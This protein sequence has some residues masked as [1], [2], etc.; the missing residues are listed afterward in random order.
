MNSTHMNDI[1]R[2]VSDFAFCYH[3]ELKLLEKRK[4]YIDAVLK[5]GPD[6]RLH[7]RRIGGRTVFSYI[8][9]KSS[10]N[11]REIYIK[12][13]DPLLPKL[14]IKYC[15]E[16][17]A[18]ELRSQIEILK[19]TPKYYDPDAIE[20]ILISLEMKFG[21]LMP[22]GFRSN[23]SRVKKWESE[24]YPRREHFDSKVREYKTNK[25][26]LVCSKLEVLAADMLYSLNI[27]YHYEERIMLADGRYKYPDFTMMNPYTRKLYYL[28]ICGKMSDTN[29]VEDLLDKILGY[30][31]TG[32]IQGDNLLLV[33]ESEKNTFDPDNLRKMLAATVLK[34]RA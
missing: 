31:Q 8:G 13:N 2:E 22:E 23:A 12:Q 30:S 33:F 27:P 1:K 24:D 15:A 3:E 16:Q 9:R 20:R 32:I 19:H 5:N 18:P 7:V 34:K 14:I 10:S 25:G 11:R 6:E 17:V 28:E 26:D 29:Y 4:K 21:E